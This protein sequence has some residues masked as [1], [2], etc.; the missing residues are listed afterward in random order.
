M[1]PGDFTNIPAH[2]KHRVDWTTS[3]EPTIWLAVFYPQA[4]AEC[5]P[6]SRSTG[7][8]IHD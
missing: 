4:R 5:R 1:K 8:P 6:N 3:D 2:R 7:S